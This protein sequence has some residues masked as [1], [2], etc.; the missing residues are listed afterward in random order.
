MDAQ[1]C[2]SASVSASAGPALFQGCPGTAGAS[3][4]WAGE[5]DEYWLAFPRHL[6]QPGPGSS[7][8]LFPLFL[9]YFLMELGKSMAWAEGWSWEHQQCPGTSPAPP[10]LPPVCPGPT[11]PRDAPGAGGDSCSHPAS[12]GSQHWQCLRF[13]DFLLFFCLPSPAAEE[14]FSFKYSPG[15]LRGNQYKSMMSKEELEEEQRIELT[16]DLTSL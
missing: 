14:T 7:P 12:S 3:L 4:Q 16:S 15:K 10:A 1:Q 6:L 5:G 9:K 11:Q 8:E 13:T 2:C